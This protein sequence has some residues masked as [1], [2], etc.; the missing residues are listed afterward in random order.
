MSHIYT[1]LAFALQRNS[2]FLEVSLAK[3]RALVMQI[4]KKH[5]IGS[6]KEVGPQSKLFPQDCSKTYSP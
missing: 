4:Q 2:S 3:F 5:F 1:S 6:Q